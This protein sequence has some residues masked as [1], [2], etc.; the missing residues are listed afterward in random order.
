M[1][2]IRSAVLVVAIVLAGCPSTPPPVTPPTPTALPARGAACATGACAEGLTCVAF[3]G[4]A[5]NQ[6]DVCEVQCG[7]GGTCPTG[8]TCRD[9]ADGPQQVCVAG[10][11][12]EPAPATQ[13]SSCADGKCAEGLSCLEY[14]GIAG[15]RGPKFTSCEI[16]CK[17]KTACPADQQCIT[18]ADGPGEVCRPR[19]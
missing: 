17:G 16:S 8:E 18:I 14:Y 10:P 6:M 13:G 19:D 2:I 7:A 9:I 4:I 5:G 11:I 12:A 3:S 1:S 15:A